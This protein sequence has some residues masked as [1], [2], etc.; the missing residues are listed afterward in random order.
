MATYLGTHGSKIQN[1][2]TD[3]DNPNT[4]EVW[5]NAT[6]NTLKFQYVNVTSAGS[7]RTGN[8]LNTAREYIAGA[9]VSNSASLG[10]GG[11]EPPTSA[12]TESYNGTSWTEGNNLNTAR[13][14]MGT[15]GGTTNSVMCVGGSVPSPASVLTESWNGTSWTEV[16]DL[17]KARV[18]FGQAGAGTVAVIAM[19]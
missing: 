2:T 5:Y 14:E 6:A 18:N 12:K 4:G 15:G 16:G 11:N 8:S 17:A 7:L 10:F 3:P 1:Y 9:G 19:A 13:N